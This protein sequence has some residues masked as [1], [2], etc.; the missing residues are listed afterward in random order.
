MSGAGER[1]R[2]FEEAEPQNATGPQIVTANHGLATWCATFD[3]Q[4]WEDPGFPE[5]VIAQLDQAFAQG[6]IAVKIYKTIGM[7]LR[8]KSGQF[9]LPDNP[10]FSPILEAIAALKVPLYIHPRSPIPLMAK[11]YR[12]DHLEHAIWGYQAETGLHALRIIT[13]GALTT[14]CEGGVQARLVFPLPSAEPA[15][16]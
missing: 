10:V 15:A 3:P 16:A 7:E 6:A 12:T 2:D 5:K 4:R 11:A 14:T 1:L 13:S 8:S 9:L